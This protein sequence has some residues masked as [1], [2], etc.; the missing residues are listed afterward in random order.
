MSP[1]FEFCKATA[2][3]CYQNKL[4]YQ[5][6]SKSLSTE[7][8]IWL[9]EDSSAVL[10]TGQLWAL[11]SSRVQHDLLP[12]ALLGTTVLPHGFTLVPKPFP[13][14]LFYKMETTVKLSAFHFPET[15]SSMVFFFCPP[16]SFA[17]SIT[18]MRQKHYL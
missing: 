6:G 16:D 8:A 7:Q 18:T 1:G 10:G 14:A 9:E 4:H 2:Y 17:Y 15:Q 11:L 5:L 3:N 13:S 12:F